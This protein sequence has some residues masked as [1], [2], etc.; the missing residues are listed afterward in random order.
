MNEARQKRINYI[1]GRCVEEG[2]CLI[3]T[4]HVSNDNLPIIS[5]NRVKKSARRKLYEAVKGVELKPRQLVRMRCNVLLCMNPE[6]MRVMDVADV[7]KQDGK[8]G[9]YSTPAMQIIRTRSARARGK[10]TLEQAR[11]IRQ[12]P[13]SLRKLAQQYGVDK[14]NIAQIKR[15]QAWI[16]H[17]NPFAGMFSQLIA[18]NDSGRKR[19]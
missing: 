10:L 9:K 6:H 5:E 15:G 14:S 4:G 18:A 12:S 1:L 16:D 3:W 2:E 19:A 13:L 11:E 17:E 8:A 7:R